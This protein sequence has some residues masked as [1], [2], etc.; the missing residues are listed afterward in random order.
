VGEEPSYTIYLVPDFDTTADA[1]SR[2]LR[3]STNASFTFTSLTPGSY[4]L[5]AFAAPVNL[6]YR[7]RDIL[8]AYRGQAVTVAPGENAD[9]VVEVSTQ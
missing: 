4:H 7:N 2:T 1:E 5:Y 6:E 8:A 3:A 9:L